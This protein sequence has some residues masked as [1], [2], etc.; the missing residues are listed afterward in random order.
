MPTLL[1]AG[2]AAHVTSVTA[3]DAAGRTLASVESADGLVCGPGNG[4]QPD[5]RSA[6]RG[7]PFT[8]RPTWS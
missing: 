2:E 6:A 8:R 4:R 1:R 3:R 5:R 7:G